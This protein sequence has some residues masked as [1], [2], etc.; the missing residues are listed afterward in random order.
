M[1]T[2]FTKMQV[3]EHIAAYTNV[4]VTSTG[5]VKFEEAISEVA[6]STYAT[7]STPSELRNYQD[8]IAGLNESFI[9]SIQAENISKAREIYGKLL[10]LQQLLTTESRELPDSGIELFNGFM[11]MLRS[12]FHG[13]SSLFGLNETQFFSAV[14][15]LAFVVDDT[16]S[17]GEEIDAVKGLIHSFISVERSGPIIYILTTFN[18][19]GTVCIYMYICA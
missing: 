18:D 16:G 1:N 6:A 2:S 11:N 4:T 14:P 19:P 5:Y 10:C 3:Y 7:C 12:Y 13:I 9:S 17:M 8:A 15:S